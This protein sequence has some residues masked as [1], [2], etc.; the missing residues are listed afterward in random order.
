MTS[1]RE[2]RIAELRDYALYHYSEI[3]RTA[4]REII[5]EGWKRNADANLVVTTDESPMLDVRG[6]SYRRPWGDFFWVLVKMAMQ[7]YYVTEETA[8]SYAKIALGALD[9]PSYVPARQ[10]P[11]QRWRRYT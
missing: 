1:L 9:F 6:M 2:K 8:K 5:E 11:K 10:Y 7:D 4:E 3:V